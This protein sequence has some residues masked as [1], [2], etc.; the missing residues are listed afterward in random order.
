M[1]N[2]AGRYG[3]SSQS[4]QLTAVLTILMSIH[5]SMPLRRATDQFEF[6]V[7]WHYVTHTV[8]YIIAWAF[9]EPEL[10]R[11]FLDHGG[12]LEGVRAVAQVWDDTTHVYQE[13]WNYTLYLTPTVLVTWFLADGR[14][15]PAVQ[16]VAHAL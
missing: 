5:E 3:A 13:Y 1:A 11:T 7:V 12:G 9:R 4:R 15:S 2:V 14:V 8:D 10:I 16:R 6:T